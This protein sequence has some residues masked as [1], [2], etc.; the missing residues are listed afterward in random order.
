MCVA[1][2]VSMIVLVEQKRK[3]KKTTV[4]LIGSYDS[5]VRVKVGRYHLPLTHNLFWN[6]F[7]FI[8]IIIHYIH[9]IGEFSW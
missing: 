2:L 9:T 1:H 3:R 8:F 7:D 5:A 4:Q 6:V